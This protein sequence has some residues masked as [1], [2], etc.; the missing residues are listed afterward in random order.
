MLT[1]QCEN[2]TFGTAAEAVEGIDIPTVKSTRPYACFKG[3]LT[4]GDPASKESCVSIDVVRYFRTKKAATPAASSVAVV[5][6]AGPAPA[7]IS[8]QRTY[9]IQDDTAPGG[10]REV[11]R[12]DLA[13]GYE[14]GRTAVHIS[15]SEA[16]VTKLETTAGLEVLGFVPQE[17]VGRRTLY[18]R[19]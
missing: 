8:T 5:D 9:R 14:Y 19:D 18:E 11:P 1:E 2:A 6:I 13:L 17:K 3:Q 16:N 15:E 7:A 10:Q 4:L 12:E